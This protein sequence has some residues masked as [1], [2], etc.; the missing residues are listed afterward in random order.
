MFVYWVHR[1]FRRTQAQAI[2]RL[3]GSPEFQAFLGMVGGY[4]ETQ[5][6]RLIMSDDCNM[7]LIRGELRAL[8]M[9]KNAVDAA[10][11]IVEQHQQRE[12]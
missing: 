8:A 12:E 6:Q 4:A 3:L 10:P 11:K 2:V 7:D 5:N 9:I 1:N